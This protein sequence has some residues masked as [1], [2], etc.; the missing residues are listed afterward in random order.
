MRCWALLALA[1]AL[2]VTIA[3][4]AFAADIDAQIKQEE[5]KLQKIERQIRFHEAELSKIKGEESG[6]L[7]ELERLNKQ[8]VLTGQKIELLKAKEKR[9][10]GRIKELSTEI[11]ENEAFLAKAKRNV[12][13]T[14]GGYI[15]IQGS[16]G[17]FYVACRRFPPRGHEHNLYAAPNN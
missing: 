6:L 4:G 12:G 13:R 5:E 15:Q 1:C 3:A 7:S 16:W 2:C 10:E 14:S 11:A 9:L 17:I 8:E